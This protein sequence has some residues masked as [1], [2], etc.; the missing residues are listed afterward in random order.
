MGVCDRPK[1]G[2]KRASS[3][4]GFTPSCNLIHDFGP[5]DPG[6][7]RNAMSQW[8]RRGRQRK[9]NTD[10]KGPRARYG[11]Q[12]EPAVRQHGERHVWWRKGWVGEMSGKLLSLP[13]CASPSWKEA[14][15]WTWWPREE[16][17]R[18]GD[19]V[20]VGYLDIV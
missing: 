20:R 11:S 18:M 15:Y 2:P 6:T 3:G 14:F 16:R 5:K 13:R 1:G 9:V 7:T 12:C 8:A 10:S 17:A 19:R 4:L